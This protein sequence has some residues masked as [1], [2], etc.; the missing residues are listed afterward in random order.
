MTAELNLSHAPVVKYTGHNISKVRWKP[1][2]AGTVGSSDTFATGSSD[3]EV[4]TK[5]S[6][7]QLHV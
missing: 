4:G 7:S 6:N 1:Q 3:E 2:P 5:W